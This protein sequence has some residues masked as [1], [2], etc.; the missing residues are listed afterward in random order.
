MTQEFLGIDHVVI[1]G[2]LLILGLALWLAFVLLTLGHQAGDNARTREEVHAAR[3][4]LMQLREELAAKGLIDIATD[5]AD[6]Q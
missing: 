5:T 3:K 6:A 1:V 4:N 2:G